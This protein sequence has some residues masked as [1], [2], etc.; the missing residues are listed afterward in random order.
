VSSKCTEELESPGTASASNQKT[1]FDLGGT[2]FNEGHI[3][4]LTLD[5]DTLREDS[6]SRE[7]CTLETPSYRGHLVLAL[8]RS[9]WA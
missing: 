4:A 7:C 8:D 9:V 3:T 5:H 6:A 2:R 1:V